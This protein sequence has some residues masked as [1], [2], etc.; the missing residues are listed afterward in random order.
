MFDIVIQL[1]SLAFVVVGLTLGIVVGR[2][3]ERRHL[4]NLA[5]RE[6]RITIPVSDLKLVPAGLSVRDAT[7]VAGQVVIGS[8]YLKTFL[9]G[10]RAI[11]GGEM[12]SYATLVERARRESLLRAVEQAQGAGA[13]AVINIRFETANIGG[14][15]RKQQVPMAEMLCYGTALF[16]DPGPHDIAPT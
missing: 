12:R 9:S 7:L 6:G 1:W 13:V 14:M 10:F 15:R 16:T 8:D 4:R 2:T 3:L 5:E 11:F